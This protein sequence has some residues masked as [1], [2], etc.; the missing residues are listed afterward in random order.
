MIGLGSEFFYRGSDPDQDPRFS[1]SMDP[2]PDTSVLQ[3][4]LQPWLKGH[5]TPLL[6]LTIIFLSKKEKER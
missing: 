3:Q 2:D 5:Y 1:R 6:T 4:N